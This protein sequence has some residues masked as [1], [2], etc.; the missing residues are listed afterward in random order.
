MIITTKLGFAYPYFINNLNFYNF[1]VIYFLLKNLSLSEV[2][3]K[4]VIRNNIKNL[5]N[6]K[7]YKGIRHFL[8]LPLRGQR[9][10]TNAGTMRR[11]GLLKKNNL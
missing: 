5:Y 7:S 2:R 11:F 3:L 1:S 9:T 4:R 8:N 6:M 10:R